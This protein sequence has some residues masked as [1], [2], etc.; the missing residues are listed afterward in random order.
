MA[1]LSDFV[2]NTFLRRNFTMLGTVFVSAFALQMAFD[3]GSDRIW[4]SIN[5]GRQWKDIKAKYVQAAEDDDE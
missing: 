2:Y 5:R 4:D 3:T 1:G